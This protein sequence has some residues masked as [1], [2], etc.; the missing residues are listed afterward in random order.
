M[1]VLLTP[2]ADDETLFAAYTLLREKPLVVL[3][4]AGAPRHG[5]FDVR[6]AEFAAAMAVLGCPWTSIAEGPSSLE[7]SLHRLGADHVYAP[8]PEADGNDDHNLVGETAA[9]LWPGRVDFYSTYT[10]AGRTTHG[11]PVPCEPTWPDLKRKALACYQSQQA[12][13]G[14]RAHFVRPLDEYVVPWEDAGAMSSLALPGLDMPYPAVPSRV[15]TC[16]VL[17]TIGIVTP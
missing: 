6:L 15:R 4:F 8:L 9:R 11:N 3:C 1:K 14:M 5:S 13:P 7:R 17:P 2:H 16:Q 12:I 10:L